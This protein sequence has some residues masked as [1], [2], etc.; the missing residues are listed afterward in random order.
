M[1]SVVGAPHYA[2]RGRAEEKGGRAIG[3]EL[4]HT[5]TFRVT[6]TPISQIA[7]LRRQQW[8]V[9]RTLCR[10]HTLVSGLGTG[11]W[12]FVW[13]I[14]RGYFEAEILSS[15]QVAVSLQERIGVTAVSAQTYNSCSFSRLIQLKHMIIP[16]TTAWPRSSR[17]QGC[18]FKVWP[19]FT[20]G[21]GSC[22]ALT[23]G[24]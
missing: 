20:P 10:S 4:I 12:D 21:A 15:S 16:P 8:G 6:H 13:T 14:R 3:H 11:L 17:V 1:L 22:K 2:E 18:K 23:S 19:V 7:N 24:M 9:C 5:H